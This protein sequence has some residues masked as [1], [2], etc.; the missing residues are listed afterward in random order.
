MKPWEERQPSAELSGLTPGQ[1][2]IYS[3]T[4]LRNV[5]RGEGMDGT[6]SGLVGT[7]YPNRHRDRL[8][9]KEPRKPWDQLYC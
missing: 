3:P 8:F 7:R 4:G 2:Q 5:H 1:H 6:D 9:T